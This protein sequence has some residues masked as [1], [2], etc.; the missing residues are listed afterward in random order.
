MNRKILTIGAACGLALAAGANPCIDFSPDGEHAL[1]L[2]LRRGD[3]AAPDAPWSYVRIHVV[4]LKKRTAEWGRTREFYFNSLVNPATFATMDDLAR[5]QETLAKKYFVDPAKKRLVVSVREDGDVFRLYLNGV[6]ASY[7]PRRGAD[8]SLMSFKPDVAFP[9]P[10]EIRIEK[11]CPRFETVDITERA[12]ALSMPGRK[13]DAK[14]AGTTIVQDG[15]PFLL[16]RDP[17]HDNVD[18]SMSWNGG[19]FRTGY[20]ACHAR[21]RWQNPLVKTPLRYQFSVPG[22]DYDALYV[23]CA[24]DETKKDTISR[25]TA[26][27]YRWRS[28]YSGSGQPYNFASEAVPVATDGKLTVVKIPLSGEMITEFGPE[29]Y[30]NFELTKDVF[31]YRTYA[32]PLNHSWHAGGLPSNV[33]VYGITLSK[34]PV[35]CSFDPLQTANIFAEDEQVGYTV[36]LANTTDEERTERLRL[37]ARDWYGKDELEE[38]EKVKLAPGERK[39][40]VLEL[41]PDRFGWYQAE[42]TAA[43]RT[44][45]HNFVRL[46]KREYD[47]R[48]FEEKCIRAGVWHMLDRPLSAA[49]AGKGG[50]DTTGRAGAYQPKDEA[51]RRAYEDIMRRY[52]MRAFAA[53]DSIWAQ[54]G[55]TAATSIEDGC[56]MYRKKMPDPAKAPENEFHQ[57]RYAAALAEPGGVRTGNAE[58]PEYYGEP[59]NAYDCNK[60]DGTAKTRFLDYKRQIQVAHK[61]LGELYPGAKKLIPHGSWNF[62]VPF[63]QDPETRGLSDGVQMDFQFYTR[64]PEEQLHQTSLNSILILKDAWRKYRPGVEPLLVWGEGP[65][66]TQVCPGGSTQLSAASHRV[67]ISMLMAAYGCNDQTSWA[68]SVIASGEN[69]CSGGLV[70]GMNALD[71]DLH[72]ATFSAW[73]RHARH[74]THESFSETG[75]A[76]A[77]CQN[78]RNHKTGEQFRAIWTV[79]GERDFIFDCRPGKLTVYDPTDNVIDAER[80]DGKAVVRAGEMPVFVYGAEG[81][82]VS[83]G[84]PDHSDAKVPEGSVKL[85]EMG[86]LDV[87]QTDDADKP[88]AE[89]MPDEIKRFPAKMDVKVVDSEKGK[90]VS[91]GLGKQEKDRMTMPYFTCLTFKKPVEIPGKA[92][93]LHLEVKAASDWGRVVYVLKDAAGRRWYSCGRAGEWNADDMEGQSVFCFDG[94]RTLRFELPFNEPWDGYRCVGFTNWGSDDL[95]AKVALPVALEK[96]FVERRSGVIYGCAFKKFETDVPV[97]LGSLYAEYAKEADKTPEA[98]RLQKIV[99]PKVAEGSLPNPIA[100][101]AK[102]GKGEPGK[103]LAVKDPDTWFDGTR[104]VF[105]FEMPTNAVSADMWMSLYPDGRGALKVGTGLKSS[106]QLVQG[107]L[108]DKTFYAF[109]VWKDKAGNLSKPS[110]SFKFKLVDHFGHQ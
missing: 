76:S 105:S 1:R 65:D 49:I 42:L 8:L 52:G 22:R 40:V 54:N 16:S 72:Y 69:H 93:A 50:W 97:L 103:I 37:V 96:I 68:T 70:V 27:F 95:N 33:R 12:N 84:E 3:A 82:A 88:Y 30:M 102:S 9:I 32:D 73:L 98:Y 47:A 48:P 28:S 78:F 75:S 19:A 77:F 94:W 7:L 58:F 51:D 107:F 24:A 89:M 71:P 110:E 25:F 85:G 91:V 38:T 4:N 106:P 100:E 62:M 34:A 39:S 74:A 92:T 104:G 56:A 109:L 35:T 90:A 14:L 64:L 23:L 61:V 43:G 81:V 79:R 67:R 18:L 99:A 60:L 41:D 26:Q 17:S 101:M 6:Y 31:V 87:V 59:E 20:T 53:P 108:A 55:I 83:L 11:T 13:S 5:W 46:R 15:I 45:K 80:R 63:L 36:T 2:E 10:F 86:A 44:W 21:Q 66:V 29:E 57:Y